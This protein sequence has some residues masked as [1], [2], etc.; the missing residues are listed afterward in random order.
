[1]LEL[2][3]TGLCFQPEANFNFT[4]VFLLK[5]FVVAGSDSSVSKCYCLSVGGCQP[6]H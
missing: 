6:C 1:L 3:F 5:A 2:E 4:Q